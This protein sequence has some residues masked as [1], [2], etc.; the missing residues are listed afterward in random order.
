MVNLKDVRVGDIVTLKYPVHGNRN[1]LARRTGE[2][3]R[4]G[5]SQSGVRYI[6]V[7]GEGGLVRSFREGRIVELMPYFSAV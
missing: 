2:V 6:T 3:I 1:I 5:V 4:T 7:Q